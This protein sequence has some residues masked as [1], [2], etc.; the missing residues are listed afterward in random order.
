MGNHQPGDGSLAMENR[1]ER[2]RQKAHELWER[3]GRPE[4]HDARHWSDAEK[5]I[6]QED[7]AEDTDELG[8]EPNP[9]R[10]SVDI[11]PAP[12]GD[13]QQTARTPASAR[14]DRG[15]RR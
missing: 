10:G 6:E 5:M 15:K 4:G 8:N 3:A 12:G 2:I 11:G 7:H 14:P 13:I 9:P 1:E